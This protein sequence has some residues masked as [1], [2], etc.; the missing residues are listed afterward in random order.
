MDLNEYETVAGGTHRRSVGELRM[1]A[2]I[3]QG[4]LE[5][6]CNMAEMK[7]AAAAARKIKDQRQFSMALAESAEGVEVFCASVRRKVQRTWSGCRRKS[8]L[9]KRGTTTSHGNLNSNLNLNGNSTAKVDSAERWMEQQ[10]PRTSRRATFPVHLVNR[11]TYRNSLR[12]SYDSN[13]ELSNTRTT[14]TTTTTTGDDLEDVDAVSV[15]SSRS[16]CA[17]DD[18]DDDLED[19]IIVAAVA[20]LTVTE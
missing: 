3:R 7:R 17:E 6:A 11:N 13:K 16:L 20:H 18:V 12:A 5:G 14:T 4:L 10:M 9:F 2:T 15:S 8:R 1:P 19:A